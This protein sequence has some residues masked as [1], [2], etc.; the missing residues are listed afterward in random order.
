MCFF[1]TWCTWFFFVVYDFFFCSLVVFFDLHFAFCSAY[2][3][4]IQINLWTLR[5]HDT[6]DSPVWEL[7][8]ARP[9]MLNILHMLSNMC[10]FAYIVYYINTFIYIL[11]LHTGLHTGLHPVS[12]ALIKVSFTYGVAPCMGVYG[13]TPP[14]RVH[15]TDQS[16]I[17]LG[18]FGLRLGICK[19]ICCVK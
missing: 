13:G 10:V 2:N 17:G 19:G 4:S 9:R 1:R 5:E 3:I 14:S 11:I 6:G 15:L 12:P 7:T 16:G 18:L 8:G